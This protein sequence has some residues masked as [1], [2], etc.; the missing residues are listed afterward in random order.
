MLNKAKERELAYL[1]KVDAIEPIEGKDRVEAAVVG[2][3]R[4]MVGKGVFKPGDIGI[5]FEIDSKL[6][7]RPEFEFTAKYHYKIRTQKFKQFYSQGLLMHPHDLGWSVADNFVVDKDGELHDINDESR[8]LTKLLG[9]TY[10]VAEDNKRKASTGDKYKKMA[11]RHQ[12]LFSKKPIRWLMRHN[13]GKKLLFL[14]F[15]KAKDKKNTWPSWV[16]KTD[17]E[18]VQNMTWIFGNPDWTLTEWYATEKV[19][20]TSTSFTMK[21]AKKSKREMLVCSRNVCFDTPKRAEKCYYDTNVYMEMAEKY[22]VKDAL[23]AI[24][25]L[26]PD[27]AFVTLQG[28]TYGAGIQKRDYSI[29]DHQFMAFNLIFGNADGT[30][31]RFNPREMTTMLAPYDIPCVPIVDPAFKLPATCEELLE[32]ATGKSAIDGLPREGLVFRDPQGQRSFKAVSNSFLTKYH[33][34]D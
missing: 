19:D 30:T 14:F 5:Y 13:W 16:V 4:T 3:W 33:G 12:K 24:L 2:G 34:G 10:A 31:K 29:K 23:S 26:N 25:D 1:I 20:G 17:E 28:E 15:G 21:Q 9:V 7:E 32:I 11:Q 22:N 27:L 8:F 6:P 18:R